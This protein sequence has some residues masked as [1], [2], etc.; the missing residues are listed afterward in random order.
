MYFNFS[1]AGDNL[2]MIFAVFAY[3]IASIVTFI[4]CERI[5]VSNH[6]LPD[7]RLSKTGIIFTSRARHRLP[8]QD[9]KIMQINKSVFIKF[10]NKMITLINVDRVYLKSGFLYF[11]AL[12]KCRIVF[13]AKKI[14]KYF[15]IN[16]I[17]DK[18]NIDTL[19]REAILDMIEH[20]FKY[21][22]CDKLKRFIHIMTKILMIKIED[23]KIEVKQN[24]FHLNYTLEYKLKDKMKVVKIN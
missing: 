17:S 6:I 14:Y 21:E 1:L 2:N 4:V 22:E 18:F 20:K 8:I 13:N 19:K 11:T 23:K 24:K 15:N 3:I 9:A 16:I 5:R 7:L 12:G 10:G